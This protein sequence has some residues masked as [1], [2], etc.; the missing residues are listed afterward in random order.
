MADQSK[1]DTIDS[2]FSADLEAGAKA[3]VE[4]GRH[5]EAAALHGLLLAVH[6]VKN[7]LPRG[8]Q[9]SDRVLKARVKRFA[10]LL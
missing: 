5:E 3:A 10:A 8:G 6:D 1:A 9:F 7:M 4:A 2:P